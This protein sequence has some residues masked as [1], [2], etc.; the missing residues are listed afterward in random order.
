M[1]LGGVPGVSTNQIGEW[2]AFYS[3]FFVRFQM[4]RLIQFKNEVR[5]IAE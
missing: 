1:H 5:A 4:A 3:D 2:I